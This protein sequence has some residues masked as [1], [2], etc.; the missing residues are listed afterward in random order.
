MNLG[1]LIFFRCLPSSGDQVLRSNGSCT[2]RPV[3]KGAPK[4]V[5]GIRQ[6]VLQRIALVYELLLF[7]CH[8]RHP[9]TVIKK[10][11]KGYFWTL[12]IQRGLSGSSPPTFSEGASPSKSHILKRSKFIFLAIVVRDFNEKRRK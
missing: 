3:L 2:V 5:Q 4:P 7:N 12:P 10:S 1:V 11:K 9:V 6:R 8:F